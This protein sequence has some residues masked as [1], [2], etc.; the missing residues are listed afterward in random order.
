M[1]PDSLP[2]EIAARLDRPMPWWKL[3]DNSDLSGDELIT[4]EA[5]SF[6][7]KL[8]KFKVA[9]VP[10]PRIDAGGIQGDTLC[11]AFRVSACLRHVR[12][13]YTYAKAQLERDL[14]FLMVKGRPSPKELNW[15]RSKGFE[16]YQLD[17]E[18]HARLTACLDLMLQEPVDN[19]EEVVRSIGADRSIAWRGDQYARYRALCEADGPLDALEI[20]ALKLVKQDKGVAMRR[21]LSIFEE[22]Q[23]LA[24]V[25]VQPKPPVP[26][27]KPRTLALMLD[28]QRI[29]DISQQTTAVGQLLGEV[30]KDEEAPANVPSPAPTTTAQPS[31]QR[32]LAVV[33]QKEAW[34]ASALFAAWTAEGLMPQAMLDELNERALETCDEL[35]L[36]GDER[37]D[38]NPT[39]L[40]GLTTA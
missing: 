24:V 26:V 23:P 20:E 21:Q 30:F 6:A 15:V 32:A 31:W 37:F 34:P 13:D 12:P 4:R 9:V 35:L 19:P 3:L 33:A 40:T 7:Q 17:G 36:E 39:A 11:I 2:E 27:K 38:V 29:A 1:R 8:S 18:S 28:V 5:G 14:A 22:P 16:G 25:T 10:D